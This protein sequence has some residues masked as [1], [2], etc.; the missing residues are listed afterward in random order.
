MN[1]TSVAETVDKLTSVAVGHQ[2]ALEQTLSVTTDL[3]SSTRAVLSL[4]E[5][6]ERRWEVLLSVLKY[7][8]IALTI[9]LSCM[10][11]IL[12]YWHLWP[13]IKALWNRHVTPGQSKFTDEQKATGIITVIIGVALIIVQKSF[14]YS[15]LLGWP[16]A[17]LFICL[18]SSLYLRKS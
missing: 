16:I 5:A 1:A 6:H 9:L 8:F 13:R 10:S 2:T 4:L 7:G 17:I 15:P 18:L 11:V 12:F 14:D 3:A